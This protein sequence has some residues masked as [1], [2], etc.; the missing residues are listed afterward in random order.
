[1]TSQTLTLTRSDPVL[2][3][4][5]APVVLLD[6]LV[7]EAPGAAPLSDAGQTEGVTARRQNPETAVRRVQLLDY[8]LHTDGAH[9][10][11]NG[12]RH[13]GCHHGN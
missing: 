1:M 12:N 9:L 2:V 10:D 5:L 4:D 13:R 3:L 8:H 6:D 7:A 11:N